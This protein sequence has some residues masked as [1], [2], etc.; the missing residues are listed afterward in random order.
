MPVEFII[1][2]PLLE[3]TSHGRFL[4]AVGQ[5]AAE[6]SL[7]EITRWQTAGTVLDV[8]DGA[9]SGWVMPAAE[10]PMGPPFGGFQA[11]RFNIVYGAT[12]WITVGTSDKRRLPTGWHLLV[13]HLISRR[14]DGQTA[15]AAFVHRG[16][17]CFQ[18]GVERGVLLDRQ[19]AEQGYDASSL[20]VLG[21]YH[22][23]Q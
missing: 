2:D 11:G 16:D 3:E 10:R 13:R 6:L 18:T 21:G 7:P 15:A 1:N 5:A 23:D 19:A 8:D 22:G 4:L 12:L 17:D 14:F 9:P 20:V